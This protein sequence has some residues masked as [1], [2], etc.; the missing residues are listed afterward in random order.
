[1]KTC[2]V[3]AEGVEPPC[4]PDMPYV[5]SPTAPNRR[6][7]LHKPWNKITYPTDPNKNN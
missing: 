2:M 6:L 7:R 3:Q 4:V 1:M 5:A